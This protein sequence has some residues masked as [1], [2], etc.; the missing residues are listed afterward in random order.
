MKPTLF[1][2]FGI[3][4]N[5]LGILTLIFEISAAQTCAAHSATHLLEFWC[6]RD[7]GRPV[8]MNISILLGKHRNTTQVLDVLK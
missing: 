3:R 7:L 5:D 4:V 1:S 6:S 2:V 8:E